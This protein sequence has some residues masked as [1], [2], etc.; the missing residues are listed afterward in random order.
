[1]YAVFAASISVLLMPQ[2]SNPDLSHPGMPPGTLVF[3][4]IIAGFCLGMPM[5]AV[6][7]FISIN[8]PKSIAGR[9][10]GM[11]TG[12]GFLGSVVGVALSASLLSV[13]SHYNASIITVI[14]VAVVF[15]V[16]MSIPMKKP[17]VF[18]EIEAGTKNV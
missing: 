5:P 15:G 1:M 2:F 6:M 17:K 7:A 9:I 14:V 8:Y 13:T 3:C 12:L 11:T 4:F 10:A 18:D 16:G